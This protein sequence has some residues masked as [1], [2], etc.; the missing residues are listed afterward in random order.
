MHSDATESAAID[1]KPHDAK[2]PLKTALL[3]GS[4]AAVAFTVFQFGYFDCGMPAA[5]TVTGLLAVAGLVSAPLLFLRRGLV[6]KLLA[7]AAVGAAGVSLFANYLTH[8]CF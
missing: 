2:R 5:S 3:V 1:A 6:G 4:V 8:L 7:V